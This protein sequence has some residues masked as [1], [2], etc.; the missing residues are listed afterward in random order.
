MKFLLIEFCGI[1]LQELPPDVLCEKQAQIR[2]LQAQLRNEEMALVLLKKIRQSQLIAEQAVAAAANVS[3]SSQNNTSTGATTNSVASAGSAS[4]RHNSVQSSGQS[5]IRNSYG[6]SRHHGHHH[7]GSTPG[8]HGAS[9]QHRNSY[10]SGIK[11]SS[12]TKVSSASAAA[13][14]RE[15]EYAR[16]LAEVQQQLNR[17]GGQNSDLSHLKQVNLVRSKSI[18]IIELCR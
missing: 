13:R 4:N 6:D 7:Q 18:G 12:G 2:K 9:Q 11:Q 8:Y 3:K 14:E 16:Q 1:V 17:K 5:G 10:G 15:R